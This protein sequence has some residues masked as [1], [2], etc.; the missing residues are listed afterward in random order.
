MTNG[1]WQNYDSWKMYDAMTVERDEE[2]DFITDYVDRHWKQ[3][4]AR[5]ARENGM[6][7]D[8]VMT[9]E[10]NLWVSHM[11]YNFL[12]RKANRVYHQLERE[13]DSYGE[14]LAGWA[15]QDSS[16]LRELLA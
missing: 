4:F 2:D 12:Q 3:E 13:P 9:D 7:L 6:P 1:D 8:E 5:M 11:T 15:A 10:E 16:N 14:G